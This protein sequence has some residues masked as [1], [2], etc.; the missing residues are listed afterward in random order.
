LSAANVT[1]QAPLAV[2]TAAGCGARCRLFC[3]VG[4]M[5]D[6]DTHL[7]EDV[8]YGKYFD[9]GPAAGVSQWRCSAVIKKN[10]GIGVVAEYG[11]RADDFGY[12]EV[13]VHETS[14]VR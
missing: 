12:P 14:G 11:W 6:P 13:L 8:G 3:G 7:V 10:G 1:R 4:T 9:R 5:Q 2:S